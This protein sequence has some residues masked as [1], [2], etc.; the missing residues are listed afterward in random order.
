MVAVTVG[1]GIIGVQ[2]VGLPVAEKQTV[3]RCAV[4]MIHYFQFITF[5]VRLSLDLSE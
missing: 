4:N 2:N 3:N 5:N 1:S